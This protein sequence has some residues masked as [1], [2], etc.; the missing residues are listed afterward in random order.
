MK[1]HLPQG[2]ENGR[3]KQNPE[4]TSFELEPRG[5][6]VRISEKLRFW[7]LGDGEES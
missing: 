2:S 4:L 3:W 7:A 6:T 5:E 1:D